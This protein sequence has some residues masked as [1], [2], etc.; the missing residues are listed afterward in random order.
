[1]SIF[2]YTGAAQMASTQ[3][4]RTGAGLFAILVTTFIMNLRHIVM[5]AC[6]MEKM[7]TGNKIQRTLLSFLITDETFAVYMSNP[8]SRPTWRF[9]LGLGIG[10][11][12]SWIIAS[13]LGAV[14]ANILPDSLSSGMSVALYAMFIALL[15][16]SVKNNRSLLLLVGL[17][18][19]ISGI[20][21]LFLSAGVVM[22]LSTL[23]GAGIGLWFVD[24]GE[25][26]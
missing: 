24:E 19:G 14:G 1:M 11:Y 10:S 26:R 2:V 4:V 8:E 7:K 17:T 9:F 21:S 16:P 25:L 20:L 15:I 23:L 18:A 13:L 3:M 6:V 12:C 22:I 5:S